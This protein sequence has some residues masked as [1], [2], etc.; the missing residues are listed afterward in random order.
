MTAKT[1]L[2]KLIRVF[3][4]FIAVIPTHLLCQM[5]ANVAGVG[6]L[7][8]TS[9]FEEKGNFVVVC[10]CLPSSSKHENQ[11]FSRRIRAVA[12]KKCEKCAARAKLLSLFKRPNKQK[13]ISSP[14]ASFFG[15]RFSFFIFWFNTGKVRTN[16]TQQVLHATPIILQSFVTDVTFHETKHLFNTESYI[17][18][19]SACFLLRYIVRCIMLFKT[20]IKINQ[21]CV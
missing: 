19:F 16:R 6:F 2:K 21:I 17:G 10:T 5:Q 14:P 1:S 4:I 13:I 3:S 8:T 9:K 15:G 12:T 20:C 18:A 7:R 11:I